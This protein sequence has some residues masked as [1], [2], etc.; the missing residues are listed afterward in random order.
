M[1]SLNKKSLIL[2]KKI[3]ISEILLRQ[4]LLEAVRIHKLFHESPLMMTKT[5][6]RPVVSTEMVLNLRYC[7]KRLS[8]N[9]SLKITS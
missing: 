8:Y 7:D 3:V 4:K 6:T 2:I 9:V 1:V 5:E